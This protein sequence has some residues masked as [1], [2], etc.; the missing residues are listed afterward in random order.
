[1]SSHAGRRSPP[2]T[3]IISL[4]TRANNF[5]DSC[6]V[7]QAE[8]PTLTITTDSAGQPL[9]ET[10]DLAALRELI[11]QALQQEGQ[12]SLV[13][14]GQPPAARLL[15]IDY[16]KVSSRAPRT[17]SRGGLIE[18][19]TDTARDITSVLDAMRL[20]HVD[21]RIPEVA[22]P[23][24]VHE[25]LHADM[26]LTQDPRTRGGTWHDQ[27]FVEAACAERGIDPSGCSPLLQYNPCLHQ[28]A[29]ISVAVVCRVKRRS[30]RSRALSSAS[31]GSAGTKKSR[32]ST[33]D[34]SLAD[35]FAQEHLKS[36]Q[37][38]FRAPLTIETSMAPT[39][40]ESKEWVQGI[41][42]PPSQLFSPPGHTNHPRS[43]SLGSQAHPHDH[44]DAVGAVDS[45][46]ARELQA[47]I[48][49]LRAQNAS[50]RS[51]RDAQARRLSALG[52]PLTGLRVAPTPDGDFKIMQ[53][54]TPQERLNGIDS[55][56][57]LLES[58]MSS[59][60]SEFNG[61][62]SA[63]IQQV[64]PASSPAYAPPAPVGKKPKKIKPEMT[65]IKPMGNPETSEVKKIKAEA[66]PVLNPETDK[67][68]KEKGKTKAQEE[69]RK[70]VFMAMNVECVADGPGHN[71]RTPCSVALV[72]P[73]GQLLDEKITPPVV[74]SYLTEITGFREIDLQDARTFE[75]LVKGEHYAWYVDLAEHFKETLRGPKTGPNA[76]FR[77]F[78]L[79]H[80]ANTL[81]P[82]P[83]EHH[84]ALGDS[85]NSIDLWN[86]YS[87][88]K[89]Q[90]QAVH[91]LRQAKKPLNRQFSALIDGVCCGAY[92]PDKC[93]CGQP[94]QAGIQRIAGTKS[95][96]TKAKTG[97]SGAKNV[98]LP[99]TL[100]P[101][102]PLPLPRAP[103][104]TTVPGGVGN[105][106]QG[107]DKYDGKNEDYGTYYSPKMSYSPTT[108]ST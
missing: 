2:A 68:I 60:R 86:L 77:Y 49:S 71:D 46:A 90:K 25:F 101:T 69:P 108:G 10:L 72:G 48:A 36:P 47:E 1:M 100:P 14:E 81:L 22:P 17:F 18:L 92:S 64:P 5:P 43:P 54:V 16:S 23:R 38:P 62:R 95:K 63:L 98:P 94:T 15:V 56:I 104:Y 97:I 89:Q 21:L 59:L 65:V 45:P 42:G 13:L 26:A 53:A 44:H 88:P 24:F 87:S 50:L 85:V 37:D 57:R 82:S 61:L 67:K 4:Y 106:V 93:S 7:R 105:N 55:T 35:S 39:G 99:P 103:F 78:S 33:G 66:K 29:V 41:L 34:T 52:S 73:L 27:T 28:D 11:S 84:T 12:F 19:G 32:L 3:I 9:R 83:Q 8:R 31:V 58:A 30:K 70:V 20:Q 76:G 6:Q 102:P 96:A 107:V 79:A 74:A 80:T 91:R 51:E 75:E 40:D